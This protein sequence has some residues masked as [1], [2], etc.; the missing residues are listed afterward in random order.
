MEGGAVNEYAWSPPDEDLGRQ[1]KYVARGIFAIDERGIVDIFDPETPHVGL[2]RVAAELRESRPTPGQVAELIEDGAVISG[3]HYTGI[4]FENIA[5][6]RPGEG[7]AALHWW[8]G[9]IY[10]PKAEPIIGACVQTIMGTGTKRDFV[11]EVIAYIERRH[12]VPV[13]DEREKGSGVICLKNGVLDIYTREL[14]THSPDYIFTSMLPISYDPD[15]EAHEIS[16]FLRGVLDDESGEGPD[17]ILLDY[18]AMMEFLGTI[19][20]PGYR[21]QKGIILLGSGAN[22]KSTWINVITAWL[23]AHNISSVSMENLGS[24]K[25]FYAAQLYGKMANVCADISRRAIQDQALIKKAIGDDLILGEHKYKDPFIFKNSA[26]MIFSCNSIPESN[27]VSRAWTRRWMIFSFPHRFDGAD[28]D[29]TLIDRLTTPTELSGLLN[30]A[31]DGLDRLRANDGVF[32]GREDEEIEHERYWSLADPVLPYSMARLDIRL[33]ELWE[34]GI[35]TDVPI[36]R[37]TDMY[38]DF[39]DWCMARKLTPVSQI[40]FSRRLGEAYPELRDQKFRRDG[41]WYWRGVDIA[42]GPM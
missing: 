7:A 31:L 32:T 23:G 39:V 33:T 26:K 41:V 17:G 36:V 14:R 25:T 30:Y 24:G 20:E 42:D 10:R 4:K 13:Q 19:L 21:Y 2:G 18:S 9:E 16:V 38:G 40:K 8:D 29:E 1:T 5:I 35:R 12:P 15:A 6:G 34:E 3:I 11:N 27:D 37:V 22:G 28:R